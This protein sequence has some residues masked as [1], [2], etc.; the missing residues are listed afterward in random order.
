MTLYEFF[1]PYRIQQSNELVRSFSRSVM[2]RTGSPGTVNR[3]QEY[4]PMILRD[5]PSMSISSNW[6]DHRRK[7]VIL[8]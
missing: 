1:C 4:S 6:T 7:T 3:R 8:T 5:G 2:K